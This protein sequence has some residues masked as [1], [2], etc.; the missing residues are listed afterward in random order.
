MAAKVE[1]ESLNRGYQTTQFYTVAMDL[2]TTD[3]FVVGGMQDNG[4]WSVDNINEQT[5]W[6]E[7]VGGDGAFAAVTTHSL[8]VSVQNG[9]VYRF[10][11][12]ED[13][14]YAGY[15]RI[16]PPTGR[17][18]LFINPYSIN[19]NNEHNIFIPAGD[20]LWRNLDITQIPT[21]SNANQFANGW[22][23]VAN[24]ANTEVI[25]SVAVSTQPANVV[26]FGTRAGKLYRF[27]DGT[28][29]VP[30]RADVTGTSFPKGANIGCIVVDPR[31]ANKVMVVFTNYKVQSLFYTTDGGATWTTVSGNLE[32]GGN[33]SGSGP[34]T[35]WATILPEKSGGTKYLVGTSTGLFSTNALTGGST[36]W[37]R[38]GATTIGQVPVDMVIS[39]TTD[40]LVLVGTHGNGV[41]S[42]RYTGPLASKEEIAKASQFGLKQ[43][44]PNPFRQGMSA[45]VPFALEKAAQV[46]LTVYDM[47]GKAVVTLVDG[48]KAAG[49]HQALWNGKGA[50]GQFV[51]SGTYLY[52]LSVDGKKSTKRMVFIR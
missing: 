18:Y 31:D 15:A 1:W 22:E 4:S 34:S 44:F 32:E 43:S 21:N 33:P 42:R 28:A 26:Y 8:F 13:G 7:R 12:R 17:G 29:A 49:Q 38:E 3:D 48:R 19:P 10:A 20:T 24:L 11:Y 35:R 30:A 6:D 52:Q 51:P 36:T 39:R 40:D 16:D 2:N 14:S 27:E 25:S 45:T 5:V 23:V 41:Y 37:L 50:S 9:T 47:T 46:K